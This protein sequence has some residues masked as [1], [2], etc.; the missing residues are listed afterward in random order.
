[1]LQPASIFVLGCIKL[2]CELIVPTSSAHQ[3]NFRTMIIS[4]GF[5]TKMLVID[6]L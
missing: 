1:M 4:F 6:T 3:M 2:S 5:G